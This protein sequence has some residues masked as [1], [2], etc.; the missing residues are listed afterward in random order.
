MRTFQRMARFIRPAVGWPVL[1]ALALL[2][3][4]V[5]ALGCGPEK[6]QPASPAPS[7]SPRLPDVPV[8]AG[9]K[10]KA[11]ES[12][13]RLAGRFRFVR[14][15]YEGN[16]T[17]RQVSEFYRRGMLTLG[18][19]LKEENLGSS[20]QRFMFEKGSD[21]CH[22]SIWDDWGLKVLIQIFPRGATPA[23][24]GAVPTR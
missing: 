13:D 15:L 6:E 4:L 16:A 23:E 5:L 3:L 2:G 21:A 8:P 12:S 17:V 20:R 24:T 22:I 1:S 14:H 18:W 7:V 19:T 10:F 9:F 11:E